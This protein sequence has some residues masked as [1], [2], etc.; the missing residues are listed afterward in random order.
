MSAYA[1]DGDVPA[2]NLSLEHIREIEKEEQLEQ[3]SELYL[4]WLETNT[5]APEFV[6]VLIHVADIES[7]P[8]IALNVLLSN[9]STIDNSSERVLVLKRIALL[10]ELLGNLE[11]AESYYESTLELLRK[12]PDEEADIDIELSIVCILFEEGRLLE[13]KER[14]EDL[15]TSKRQIHPNA[16]ILL[17]L[18]RI[19]MM[20]GDYIEA[21]RCYEQVLQEIPENDYYSQ[22]LI[23]MYDVSIEE[24]DEE[25]ANAFLE[26]LKARFQRTPEYLLYFNDIS[27]R[28]FITPLVLIKPKKSS[29]VGLN[30]DKSSTQSIGDTLVHIQTGSFTSRENALYMVNELSKKGFEAEI[31]ESNLPNKTYH[32]VMLIEAYHPDQTLEVL[33]KLKE[34][35]FEGFRVFDP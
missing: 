6:S 17:L 18:G 21:K 4:R 24:G 19:H 2:E 14:L 12:E 34:A 28:S 9:L 32:R 10:N 35:G 27:T 30:A 20:E 8:F 3:A 23:G 26:E 33:L 22:A 5:D 1:D 16:K 29:R 13:A 11:L 31:V 25:K 15:I 7:N